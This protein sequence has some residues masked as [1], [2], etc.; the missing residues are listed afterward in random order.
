MNVRRWLAAAALAGSLA[1]PRADSEAAGGS[2]IVNTASAM[3][4]VAP[5]RLFTISSNTVQTVVATV[6]AIAISPKEDGPDPA[7]ET[8]GAGLPIERSFTITNGG[9]VSDAYVITSVTSGSGTV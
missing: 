2:P 1:V 9:N 8:F 3:F 4:E 7:S 6:S 5:G